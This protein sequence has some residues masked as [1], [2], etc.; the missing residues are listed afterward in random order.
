MKLSIIIPC[1]NEKE[2]IEKLISLVKDSL[3]EEKE[4]ILVDGCSN[5][6]ITELI[7]THLESLVDN[8]SHSKQGKGFRNRA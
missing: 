6:G 4:I 2:Y 1:F 3:F 8:I 5:E 7:R